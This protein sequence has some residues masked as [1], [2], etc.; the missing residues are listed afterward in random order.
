MGRFVP[1]GFGM[2]QGIK[3]GKS[4]GIPCCKAEMS[5]TRDAKFLPTSCGVFFRVL[6]ISLLFRFLER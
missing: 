5:A 4:K 2:W 1:L 6:F 3:G